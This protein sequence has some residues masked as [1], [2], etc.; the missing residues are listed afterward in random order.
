MFN[1]ITDQYLLYNYIKVVCTIL[2]WAE[3]YGL[4][5]VLSLAQADPVVSA[6]KLDHGEFLNWVMGK[7]VC[8]IDIW[9]MYTIWNIIRWIF[10]IRSLNPIYFHPSHYPHEFDYLCQ[11]KI[12]QYPRVDFRRPGSTIVNLTGWESSPFRVVLC[13]NWKTL[14]IHLTLQ[15]EK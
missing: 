13:A 10:C 6:S 9:N 5:Q 7:S 3:H 4:S 14:H 12:T 1:I 11:L 15:Q 8:C 2:Q